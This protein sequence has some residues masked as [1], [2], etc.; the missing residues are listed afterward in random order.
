M[1]VKLMNDQIMAPDSWKQHGLIYVL[2]ICVYRLW[3]AAFTQI[4]MGGIRWLTLFIKTWATKRGQNN[5]SGG[6]IY[7][8]YLLN[9]DIKYHISHINT[10]KNLVMCSHTPLHWTIPFFNLHRSLLRHATPTSCPRSRVLT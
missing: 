4:I 2:L 3:R 7:L 10:W 1:I 5:T 8:S 9:Y 6:V